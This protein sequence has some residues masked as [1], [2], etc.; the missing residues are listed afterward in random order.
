[1]F[2]F[3]TVFLFAVTLC[4]FGNYINVRIIFL[5]HTKSAI[6]RFYEQ[7]PESNKY[8]CTIVS[9]A[10][11]QQ[12]GK[13]ITHNHVWWHLRHCHSDAHAEFLC[14]RQLRKKQCKMSNL[15]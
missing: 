7:I 5:G 9:H 6:W 8:I 14:N 15:G 13:V 2:R 1:M 3:K 4:C 10:T 11:Q 12:C